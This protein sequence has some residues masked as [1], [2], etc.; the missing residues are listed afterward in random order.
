MQYLPRVRLIQSMPILFKVNFNIILSRKSRYQC[1][2]IFLFFPQ[3]CAHTSYVR[4]V[5]TLENMTAGMSCTS[6]ADSKCVRNVN[7]WY[8][9]ILRIFVF[10]LHHFNGIFQRQTL[11]WPDQTN[12]KFCA[13]RL[14]PLLRK[15]YSCPQ[16]HACFRLPR[17]TP[18]AFLPSESVLLHRL[19]LVGHLREC[20]AI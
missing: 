7:I 6:L 17:R 19:R 5:R 13:A 18:T 8:D 12:C 16:S 9:S 20:S 14:C 10:T 3:N 4:V 1:C 11:L 15:A 2:F